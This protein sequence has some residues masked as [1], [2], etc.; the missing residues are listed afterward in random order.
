MP[1]KRVQPDFDDNGL[2]TDSEL[3]QSERLTE[4]ELKNEKAE[5]QKHMAWVAMISMLVFT[6]LLFVPLIDIERVNSLSQLLGYFYIAQAGV[7]GAYFGMTAWM[8]K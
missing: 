5:A 6:G 1:A 3:S 2:L 7:V 4:L 8:S